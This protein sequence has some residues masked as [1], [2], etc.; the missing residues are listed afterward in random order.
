M[1]TE[2]GYLNVHIMTYHA[3]NDF[4]FQWNA[5]EWKAA[6]FVFLRNEINERQKERE[7][8]TNKHSESSESKWEIFQT[9]ETIVIKVISFSEVTVTMTVGGRFDT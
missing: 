5:N 6:F 4:L 1:Q 7:K 9:R 2:M 8:K 3:V